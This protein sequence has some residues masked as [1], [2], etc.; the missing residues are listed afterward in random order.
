M[1]GGFADLPS[2]T[3]SLLSITD[4][5]RTLSGLGIVKKHLLRA[6]Q[7]V[8]LA[9]QGF[10]QFADQ[11]IADNLS[12]SDHQKGIHAAISYAQKTIRNLT[13]QLPRGDEEQYKI[14]R[15][16]VMTSILEVLEA[17]IQKSG[18]RNNQKA[19]MKAEVLE[20]IRNVLLKEMYEQETTS[21]EKHDHAV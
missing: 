14:L 10:L 20:A 1:N 8:L 3:S 7:E 9:V 17:E 12:P 11:Q 13:G 6:A 4:I 19:K 16:K 18:R 5:V 2:L 21:K 15:R